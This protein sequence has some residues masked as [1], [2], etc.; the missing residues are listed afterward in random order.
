MDSVK[1]PIAPLDGVLRYPR[2]TLLS[3]VRSI[4]KAN[5]ERYIDLRSA[6]EEKGDEKE[7]E[8]LNYA[9]EKI[10]M[11]VFE[12]DSTRWKANGEKNQPGRVWNA[13]ALQHFADSNAAERGLFNQNVAQHKFKWVSKINVVTKSVGSNPPTFPGH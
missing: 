13:A 9:I 4:L 3:L 8:D 10:T 7:E 11:V 5:E 2:D 12:L 6:A 1:A